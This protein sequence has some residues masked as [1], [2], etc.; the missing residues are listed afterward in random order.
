[1]PKRNEDA[2]HQLPGAQQ[3]TVDEF[4]KAGGVIQI[5]PDGVTGLTP[6]GE[7]KR[8]ENKSWS[9]SARNRDRAAR[10]PRDSTGANKRKR[11]TRY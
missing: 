7:P 3:M 4:I 9:I 5:I 11:K 2:G 1:M 8:A 10:A 6:I